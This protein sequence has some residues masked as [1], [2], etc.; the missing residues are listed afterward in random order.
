MKYQLTE[1]ING[2]IYTAIVEVTGT[3]SLSQTITFKDH[4]EKDGARYRKGDETI[5]RA[6]ATLIFSQLITKGALGLLRQEPRE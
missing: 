3:R 2:N 5:M 1:T 6:T 4:I